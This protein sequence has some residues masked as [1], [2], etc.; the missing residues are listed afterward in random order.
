MAAGR[1]SPLGYLRTM[2]RPAASAVFAWDDPW[3]ALLDI[4]LSAA[5]VVTR[6]LSRRSRDGAAACSRH[7]CHPNARISGHTDHG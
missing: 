4:P 2:R 1:L 5:R 3:P 7:G 6:R